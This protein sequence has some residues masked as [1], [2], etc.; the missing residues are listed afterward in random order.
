MKT[1]T[2]DEKAEALLGYIKQMAGEG[3]EEELTRKALE[4]YLEMLQD[5]QD[6]KNAQ[7]YLKPDL[8]LCEDKQTKF[9]KAKIVVL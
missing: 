6:L 4:N 3:S 7:K 9:E 1:I 5:A 2:L 8:S